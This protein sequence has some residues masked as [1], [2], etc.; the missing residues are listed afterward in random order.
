MIALP[1]WRS[2]NG[3]RPQI[4]HLSVYHVLD[5][6]R[7]SPTL[8]SIVT[9]PRRSNCHAH[10]VA[11][12]F[13]S[14]SYLSTLFL[15]S[16]MDSIYLIYQNQVVV[17]RNRRSILRWDDDYRVREIEPINVRSRIRQVL[18]ILK[19]VTRVIKGDVCPRF[20]ELAFVLRHF[21]DISYR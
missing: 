2:G 11:M 13:L 9:G 10:I 6:Q 16:L 21:A 19:R 3:F 7:A 20:Y 14:F 5:R 18:I 12:W 1:Y 4:F 17:Y 8:I 15:W